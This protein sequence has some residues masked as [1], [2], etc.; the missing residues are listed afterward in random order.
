MALTSDRMVCGDVG[1]GRH[2]TEWG[3][4]MLEVALISDRMGCGD[5]GSGTDI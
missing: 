5:V 4:G 1:S 2:L 3:V